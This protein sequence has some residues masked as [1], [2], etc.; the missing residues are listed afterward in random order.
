MKFA[1][2]YIGMAVIALATFAADA[3]DKPDDAIPAAQKSYKEAIAKAEKALVESFDTNAAAIRE[4]S[5]KAELKQALLDQIKQEK[6]DFEQHG[7]YPWSAQSRPALVAFIRD[8]MTADKALSTAFDNVADVHTKAKR[9]V[10]AA[11]VLRLKKE[12]IAPKMIA[13]WELT[14]TNWTGSWIGKLYSNGHY[15]D[16]DGKA[17]WAI[18]KGV[19][20]LRQPEQGYPNGVKVLKWSL[21]DSGT[22]LDEVGNNGA[23][24]TGK[25]AN[26]PEEK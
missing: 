2:Y 15:S 22:E 14:G 21:K 7:W 6:A 3:E 23:R 17:I 9:D 25:L 5:K 24:S 20:T 8:R 19:V 16:A 11:A 26:V 4:S 12:A 13:R 1:R 10:A 18:E